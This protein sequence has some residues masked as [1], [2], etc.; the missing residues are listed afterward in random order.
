MLIAWVVSGLLAASAALLFLRML[1][2]TQRLRGLLAVAAILTAGG[3]AA[4]F[5]A[6][7]ADAR[8]ARE[9][10]FLSEVPNEGRP[11]GYVSSQACRACH[12]AEYDSW[13]RSYHRTMTQYARPE[14]VKADFEGAPPLP[15]QEGTL[16]LERRGDEF[17][18]R[19]EPPPG[20][21]LAAEERRVG[22]VTGSHHKQFFW[23]TAGPRNRM[24][25][26]PYTFLLEDRRWVV[27]VDTFLHVPR[28]H[29][30]LPSMNIPASWNGK[31]LS[32]HATGGQPRITPDGT[33]DTRAA[34]LGIACE[35]CHGPGQAH[36]EAN[37]DPR[38]RYA[39]ARAGAGDPTI[40]NPR[41]LPPRQSS[42]TC[43]Q[44][45]SVSGIGDW[46]AYQREGLAFKPGDDLDRH[47][48][49][50]V[51]GHPAGEA[52]LT[53]TLE[54]DPVFVRSRFWPD[55]VTRVI[56]REW[57]AMARS[58]CHLEGGMTCLSCHSMHKSD[59]NDQLAAGA[60]GDG[61][62]VACHQ[63]IGAQGR[64]HTRHAP[65]TPGGRCYDCHMPY[66]TYGLLKAS[67]SH[68]VDSPRVTT[69]LATG[70]PEACALCH[71]D[72][73]RA[74]IAEALARWYGH[75]VPALSEEDR[76][77]AAGAALLLRGDAAQ[78]ALVAA[79]MGQR[80]AQQAS[81]AGWM[82]RYLTLALGDPYPAV[83]YLAG[84]SLRT[85]P[86]F[87]RIDYD[88]VAPP[89]TLRASIGAVVRRW[90]ELREPFGDPARADRLLMRLD[91]DLDP[92]RAG[93]LLGQRDE[94]PM[95]VSE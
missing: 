33:M 5:W 47:R 35:S 54:S 93:A 32:C 63:E 79:A 50:L 37:A 6:R 94:R 42:E 67:R 61:A 36:V 78:R 82:A 53:D 90:N 30:E 9:A 64:A 56:G 1:P 8:A 21:G 84:R 43:G 39:I 51:P 87:E 52:Q 29:D 17:W 55:G 4:W 80:D 31:C 28:A 57:S 69:A 86:G 22:L 11:G 95:M 27:G 91:G 3:G 76:T 62:C 12:P 48:P 25:L 85:L 26:L 40:V 44:C 7:R 75:P 60:D 71:L 72:Q 34:E 45:H 81:G 70:R 89:P 66:T 16:R 92:G 46:D 23:T 68:F 13:A 77:T 38:R 20:S 41:R 2:R 74:W 15:V 49:A 59:P 18:A 88:F 19:V 10:T 83:R 24:G 58:K 14:A 65:G 73:P